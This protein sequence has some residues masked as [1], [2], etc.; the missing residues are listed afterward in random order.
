MR[1][2]GYYIE[3]EGKLGKYRIIKI[4]RKIKVVKWM[5]LRVM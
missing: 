4:K 2:K 1:R 3:I 5:D